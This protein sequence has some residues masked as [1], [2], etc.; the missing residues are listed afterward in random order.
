MAFYF[1]PYEI[2]LMAIETEEAGMIFYTKVANLMKDGESKK[3]LVF[4]AE[5]ESKHKEIFEKLAKDT[6]KQYPEAE[7]AIDVHARMASILDMIKRKSFDLDG[8]TS[9]SINLVQALDVGIQTEIQSISVYQ[10]ARKTMIDAFAPVLDPI[11]SE[12]ES[13][14]ELLSG[15]RK[16][17][18]A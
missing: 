2:A 14:L 11:I 8:V 7:Y 10:L 3:M 15:L 17:Q 1:S 4:L 16:K 12:E 18:T 9:D 6:E 5:Q 13:H